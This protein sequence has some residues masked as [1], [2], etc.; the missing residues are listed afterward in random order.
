MFACI[1]EDLDIEQT[2]TMGLQLVK[3]LAEGQ[4]NGQIDIDRT[5]GTKFKIK[6]KRT[7]HKPRI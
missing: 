5:G 3:V 4:L 7:T 1:S 2:G 6:F